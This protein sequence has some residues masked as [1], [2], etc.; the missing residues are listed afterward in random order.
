M[1]EGAALGVQV[2]E[3]AFLRTSAPAEKLSLSVR[4]SPLDFTFHWL[5]EVTYS[6]APVQKTALWTN[7]YLFSVGLQLTIILIID[8]FFD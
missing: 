8:Y 4:V 2:P 1:P 7:D 5:S 3:R 6:T